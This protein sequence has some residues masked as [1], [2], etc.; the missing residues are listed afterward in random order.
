VLSQ[1]FDLRS[2][3]EDAPLATADLRDVLHLQLNPN[4]I[5]RYE[6]LVMRLFSQLDASPRDESGARKP[7]AKVVVGAG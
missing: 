6:D 7:P 1:V 2:A 4:A 3:G 5:M